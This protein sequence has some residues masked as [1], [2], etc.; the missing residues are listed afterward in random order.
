MLLSEFFFMS[1]AVVL[2][3]RSKHPERISYF[4]KNETKNSITFNFQI[5]KNNRL[6]YIATIFFLY[7]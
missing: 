6:M 4:G 7:N 1:A 2:W 3:N 5:I